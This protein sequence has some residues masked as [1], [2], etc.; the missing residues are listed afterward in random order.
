M[1]HTHAPT[2]GRTDRREVRNSYVDG[3]LKL[4]LANSKTTKVTR[5]HRIDQTWRWSLNSHL[6]SEILNFFKDFKWGTFW[7]FLIFKVS[8]SRC[9]STLTDRNGGTKN[10]ECWNS[11]GNWRLTIKNL[12]WELVLD[13]SDIFY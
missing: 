5:S 13:S 3:A 9:W 10:H 4:I 1:W 7:C 12:I 8:L 11:G 2:N 6:V